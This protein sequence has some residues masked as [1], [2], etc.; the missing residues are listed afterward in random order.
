MTIKALPSL[1][2]FN[3]TPDSFMQKMALSESSG[4]PDAEITL[5]DGHTFTGLYQ[6][7]DAR[8]FDYRNAALSL[9]RISLS[10]MKPC[11][12]V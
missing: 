9:Q 4:R 8:L 12:N 3:A 5:E 10:R 11:K 1:K 6:F 2:E 7:G